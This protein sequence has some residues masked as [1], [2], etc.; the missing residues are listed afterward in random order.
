M[1][2]VRLAN[3]LDEQADVLLSMIDVQKT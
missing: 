2:S 3:A 1:R